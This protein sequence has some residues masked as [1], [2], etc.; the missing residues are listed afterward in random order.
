MIAS[1]AVLEASLAEIEKRFGA[2]GE[3]PLPPFWAGYR[4]R[5]DTIEFWQG[6][7]DRTHDRF[8]Y[9]RQP[10]GSWRIDRLSP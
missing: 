3:V 1:R 8:E 4:V 5:P 9:A 6:R 7:A 2:E 10:D